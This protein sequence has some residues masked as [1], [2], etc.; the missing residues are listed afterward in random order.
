M[1]PILDLN[2]KNI[3]SLVY[4]KTNI[5]GWFFDAYLK[6]THTSKL[7]ITSQPVQS[8]SSL[9]DNAYMQPRTLD[10]D[11]AMSDSA[12][13]LVSGQ[14][15]SSKSRAVTAYEVLSALQSQRIPTQ[16]YTKYG[17]Y[18]DMLLET[19][20]VQDD[21]TTSH[22]MKC[23]ASFSEVLVATTRTVKISAR[24]VVSNKP[25]STGKPQTTTVSPSLAYQLAHLKHESA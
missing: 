19:L 10:I 2:A 16:I 9:T 21:F 12:T 3:K 14:F 5:G 17:T 18:E 25:A 6:F 24:P 7:T 1:N 11:I 15:S 13:S 20:T 8:G 23:T 4:V 22:A